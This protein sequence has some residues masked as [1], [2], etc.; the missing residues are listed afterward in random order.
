MADWESSASV[1]EILS[2]N[3]VAIPNGQQVNQTFDTILSGSAL[4][5]LT[6]PGQAMFLTDGTYAVTVSVYGGAGT[7]YYGVTLGLDIPNNLYW[8]GSAT[9]PSTSCT[10][11]ATGRVN[12]GTVLTVETY[13]ATGSDGNFE[14]YPISIVKLA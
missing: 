8:Q 3:N 5:D 2:G 13:N 7:G 1:Q 6:T 4:V 14:I 12:A 9:G 10:V 11:S